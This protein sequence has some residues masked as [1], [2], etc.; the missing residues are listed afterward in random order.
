MS[1]ANVIALV[2]RLFTQSCLVVMKMQVSVT[3]AASIRRLTALW[4][5]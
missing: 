1:I 4:N 5:Q 2:R 3:P